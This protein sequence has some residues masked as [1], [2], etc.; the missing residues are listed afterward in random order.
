MIGS[1][2]NSGS[3]ADRP[4]RLVAVHLRHHHV[5]QDEV[6]VGVRLRAPR[7]PSRPFSAKSTSI[8][9]ASSTL[10]EREDVADVVVDD[11]DLLAARRR[12][13]R[14]AAARASAASLGQLRLDAVQEERRLVEQPLGRAGV[15]DDDRLGVALQR[16][17]LA[18]GQLLAGVD[19]HRQRRASARSSSPA[20]AGRS[21][22]IFGSF[23]SST[24]QSKSRLARAPRAPPR[25]SRRATIS[26]SRR[27]R[28]ARRSRSAAPRRPRRRAAGGRRGR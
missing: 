10:V 8:P 2:S 25:A 14:C 28:R 27:R 3:C 26:T 22:V 17:L 19:D 20:R 16:R 13:R 12:R 18:P 7:S 21:R 6:D 15:L 9:C 5:H 4:H 23:R 11:Q 1:C 24:M